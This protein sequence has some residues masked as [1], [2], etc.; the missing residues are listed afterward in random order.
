[1]ASPPRSRTNHLGQPVGLDLRSFSG[2]VPPESEAMLG[3]RCRLVAVDP[4]RHAEALHAAYAE[5]QDGGNWTY[6]PYGPFDSHE[7]YAKLLHY[8][9]DNEDVLAFAIVDTALDRPLGVA[10]YLRP[11]PANGAIEVGHLSFAPALQRTPISTEAM[12]LMMRRVFEDW[13]Y[14]RY[15]WKCDS[16]NAPSVAAARRLGFR[17]EGTFRNH[18]F[19]KGRNRDTSWFSILDSEWPEIREA[20]ERWLDAANFDAIGVQRKRLAD[21]MPEAAGRPRA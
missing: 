9:H 6:L 20:L 1:M 17:Y 2:S 15:E 3:S 5:D 8:L 14:R 18:V 10:T 12:Y 4:E 13:G 21:W 11:D 16:L 19:V 7:A